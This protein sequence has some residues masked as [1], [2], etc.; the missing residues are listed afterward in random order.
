MIIPE[1]TNSKLNNHSFIKEFEKLMHS[2]ELNLKQIKE[3][4]NSLNRIETNTPPY[5]LAAKRIFLYL[6]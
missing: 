1:V 5:I 4:N 2:N 6:N 3:I